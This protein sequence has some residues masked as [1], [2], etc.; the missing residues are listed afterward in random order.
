M[1][2]TCV[3]THAQCRRNV[4]PV[5]CHGLNFFPISCAS[6]PLVLIAQMRHAYACLVLPYDK[7]ILTRAYTRANTWYYGLTTRSD[8]WLSLRLDVCLRAGTAPALC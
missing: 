4:W 6:V 5:L 7:C 3:E 1:S 2:A 8:R